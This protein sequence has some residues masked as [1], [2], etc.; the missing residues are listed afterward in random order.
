[1]SDGYN[2][3]TNYETWNAALWWGENGM[4]GYWI[5]EAEEMLEADDSDDVAMQLADRM[6]SETIDEMPTVTGMYADLLK[7][8]LDEVNWREIAEHYVAD[9]EFER[10]A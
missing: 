9:A 5:G 2:G 1:M 8:A 6:K 7:A 10:A 3:W 4:S